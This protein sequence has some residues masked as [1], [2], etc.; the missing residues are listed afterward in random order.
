M[1]EQETPFVYAS[2]PD[3]RARLVQHVTEQG[4]CT[5]IELAVRF[6]VSEMTIRRDVNALVTEGRLRSFHGGVGALSPVEALGVDYS[7]RNETKA[8]AKLAIARHAATMIGTGAF[9]AL[10]AGTTAAGVAGL[11]P[12]DAHFQVITPSLPVVVALTGHEGVEVTCLGGALHRESRSFAGPATLAAISNLQVEI[13]FLAASGLSERGAFCGNGFDAIT[14]RALIEVADR[15]VL[16]ADSSKF[17][18]SAMV[19]VCGWDAIDAIITDEGLSDHDREILDQS[20]V[21]VE[22]VSTRQTNLELSGSTS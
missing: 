10:D 6:G 3:R 8:E 13:L 9:V 1:P 7:A 12:T 14:K 17:S 2:V 21:A 11:L 22:I 5:I 4:Y 15:V 19:R 18:S 20:E 16:L